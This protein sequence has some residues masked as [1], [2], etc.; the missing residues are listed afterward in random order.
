MENRCAVIYL[1]TIPPIAQH[2]TGAWAK[3]YRYMKKVR[4]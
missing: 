4:L 1:T 2:T 3:Q